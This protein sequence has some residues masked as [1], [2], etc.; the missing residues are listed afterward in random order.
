MQRLSA[1]FRTLVSNAD[2]GMIAVPK[3]QA[4]LTDP[5]FKGFDVHVP[6]FASKRKPDGW[7]HPSTHPLWTERQ[8]YY[9][10][11]QPK[12]LSEYPF[13]ASGA[14]AVTVGSTLHDTIQTVALA[15]GM[16]VD[17][18]KCACGSPHNPAEL[19]LVDEESGTRGHSDGVWADTDDGFEIK[20]AHSAVVDGLN[21][22]SF[23]PERLAVYREKKPQYYAQN[24][25]YL[26][27]SG[28]DL[29]IVM[30]VGTQYPYSFSEVHVP[31]DRVEAF[32][33]RDKY[34]R[35][36]QAVAD[37]QVPNECCGSKPNCLVRSVC[38]GFLP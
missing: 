4:V 17:F 23:G 19:M 18:G 28:R 32:R 21:K 35:V 25:E 15:N 13:D 9:Y 29:M 38:S 27:M 14:L 37:G 8:L 10:L 31:F 36:R 16:L 1:T 30:F 6:G 20:T 26:R 12:D 2:A 22:V 33:I 11:T 34:M 5:K 7:F 3:M 24:Q